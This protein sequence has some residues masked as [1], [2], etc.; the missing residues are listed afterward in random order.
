MDI[1]RDTLKEYFERGDRPTEE[2]FV[3]LIDS[4]INKEDD[5]VYVDGS[6]LHENAQIGL[7]AHRDAN[8]PP[9]GDLELVRLY[10][11]NRV[12]MNQLKVRGGNPQP[13]KLLFAKDSTG[14]VEWRPQSDVDD[15]DWKVDDKANPNSN[16][17]SYFGG[18][19]GI[20]TQTPSSKLT[21]SGSPQA[22]SNTLGLLIHHTT[23]GSSSKASVS[24]LVQSMTDRMHR[25]ELSSERTATHFSALKLQRFTNGTDATVDATYLNIDARHNNMEFNTKGLTTTGVFRFMEGNLGIG[26]ATPS[27]KLHVAG[28]TTTSLLNISNIT[29]GPGT[30]S[31]LT[32]DANGDVH[33]TP[34]SQL[35]PPG[36]DLWWLETS[37]WPK[38]HSKTGYPVCVDNWLYVDQIVRVQGGIVRNGWRNYDPPSVPP[39]N[40]NQ[41]GVDIIPQEPA[42]PMGLIDLGLYNFTQ[43]QWNRYVTNNGA[44]RFYVDHISGLKDDS[45]NSGV[46]EVIPAGK[47]NLHLPKISPTEYQKLARDTVQVGKADFMIEGRK[48]FKVGTYRLSIVSKD[49]G[50]KDENDDR[51]WQGYTGVSCSIYPAASVSGYGFKNWTARVNKPGECYIMLVVGPNNEWAIRANF[52]NNMGLAQEDDGDRENDWWVD[53]VFIH[54]GIVERVPGYMNRPSQ[55]NF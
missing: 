28:T 37:Q 13:G 54:E 17:Y 29:A 23:A 21:I 16:M 33:K 39:Y 49:H 9:V 55:N 32:I 40:K 38:I 45:D 26:T 42:I 35:Y 7:G 4:L 31:V 11:D 20:G 27:T 36:H 2:Q 14:N 1:N 44:H 10:V 51:E 8:D 5:Q 47:N 48:P 43:W 15:K 24:L 6:K 53:V 41:T 12:S 34:S 52:A 19:V 25:W 18:N 3:D 46:F 30:N 22:P 50:N